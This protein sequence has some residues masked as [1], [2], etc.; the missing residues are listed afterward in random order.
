[1]KNILLKIFVLLIVCKSLLNGQVD[2][3]KFNSA[4]GLNPPV[5]MPLGKK[6][7][8]FTNYQV[9]P[10]SNHQ[11]EVSISISPINSNKLAAGANTDPG[12]GFYYST[13]GSNTWSGND[14]LL[15]TS[16]SATDP[17]LAFD[18][19]G[20]AFF[21]YIDVVGSNGRLYL[22]KSTNGG[23]NWN[24]SVR[25]DNND[26]KSVDKNYMAIDVNSNSTYKN[27]LYFVWTEF[28]GSNPIRFCR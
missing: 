24:A 14:H 21:N 19:K 13:D 4:L 1:M 26:Q 22:S 10:T 23:I 27:N 17:S 16:V 2:L 20:N 25:V 3:L 11:S 28:S 8:Q 5:T 18:R 15:T 7:V 12:Q 9:Y 6:T